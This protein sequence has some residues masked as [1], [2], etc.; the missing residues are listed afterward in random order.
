MWH[1]VYTTPHAEDAIFTQRT[2]NIYF[3]TQ[4]PQNYAE[5][6]TSLSLVCAIRRKSTSEARATP[7]REK[8]ESLGVKRITRNLS[9]TLLSPLRYPQSLAVDFV[10]FQA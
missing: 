4:T 1:A 3:R 6:H 10:G 7:A 8:K 2:M 5:F 9:V